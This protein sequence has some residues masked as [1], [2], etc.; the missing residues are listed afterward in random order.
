MKSNIYLKVML[1]I[2]AII[3]LPHAQGLTKNKPKLVLLP[4]VG[5]GLKPLD[6]QAYQNAIVDALLKEY[7]VFSGNQVLE[8]LLK[9]TEMIDC[10]AESCM[11]NIAIAFNGE[12]VARGTV[13]FKQEGT[14]TLMINIK[15]VFNDKDILAKVQECAKCSMNDV[16]TMFYQMIINKEIITSPPGP[17]IIKH[18]Q[19]PG[20]P[21]QS[22]IVRITPEVTED[23]DSQ[24]ATVIIESNP[25][26]ADVY[27]GN[28]LSGQTTYQMFNLKAGQTVQFTIKKDNYHPKIIEAELKGGFNDF[29]TIH[30]KPM[31]GKLIIQSTPSNAKVYIAGKHVGQTPYTNETYPSGAVF[32]SIRKE[33]YVPV[34]NQQVIIK[35]EETT[36]QTFQLE[37]N[38]GVLII[39]SDPEDSE[40]RLYDRKGR[41]VITESTPCEIKTHPGKYKLKISRPGYDELIYDVTLARNSTKRITKSDARLRRK[42]GKINITSEPF[43]RGAIIY[44]NDDIKGEIPKTL[45]LPIGHYTIHV[46]SK[47]Y[48][49]KE[50]IEVTD[51]KQ[52]TVKVKI[53]KGIGDTFTN[54]V[55]LSKGIGDTF[56]NS[57][58]MTFVLIQPGTF[59]MGSPSNEPQRDNDETQHQVTLTKG[60]YIQ[61][62]EVTQGQWQAIMGRNPSYFSNCGKDCPVENVSWDDV[63]DF[64]KQLNKKENTSRYRLPT[65]AEW[66]YA[67]RAGSKG[68]FAFGDCLSTNEANYNGNYPLTGCSKGEYRKTP[69]AV[70]S[71]KANAWG[72]YDMHGNV[73][74]W[75]Q[76]RYGDYPNNAVSD[77]Q[78][79]TSG[80][81]RVVRGGSWYYLAWDC[82]S[83]FRYR[84][85]P[86]FRFR[87]LGFRLAA[88]QRQ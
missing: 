82:R 2:L 44:V 33:L 81:P 21:S 83:A 86:G 72:L 11:Q 63:Q 34:E 84:I 31:F 35:D 22:E 9:E 61:T 53:S 87:D 41:D 88:F 5:K 50:S 30:L 38:F 69:I 62:T 8:K 37:P 73:W 16:I 36:T 59:M 45:E 23:K 85:E 46:K 12:L 51:G 71:L 67:A 28:T 64:I 74:E 4:I 49:G 56:T 78:G 1:L 27:L 20:G 75:C 24:Y 14:Y 54:K 10:T 48:S 3:L 76:D 80:G 42:I 60:Y 13:E 52:V 55:K 18:S 66:E 15:N 57:L 7:E 65:E 39:N 26:Q 19:I 40:V 25:T 47:E 6:K 17:I 77:P 43:K 79:P 29:K 70:G 58:N 68:P 32:V